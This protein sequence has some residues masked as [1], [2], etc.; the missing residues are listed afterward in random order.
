MMLGVRNEDKKYVHPLHSCYFNFDEKV[1]INGIKTYDL[2][3]KKM[4]IV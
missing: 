1:L 3:L 4:N 2:I